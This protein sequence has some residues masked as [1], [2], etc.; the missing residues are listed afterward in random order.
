MES[1]DLLIKL[2]VSALLGGLIGMERVS[3][4]YSPA[5]LRTN[6]I[7]SMSTCLFTVLCLQ[8]IDTGKGDNVMLA[9]AIS[10]VGFLGA[11]AIFRRDQGHGRTG[12]LTTAATIWLV[13]GIGMAVGMGQYALGLFVTALSLGI[14]HFLEPFSEWL[15][16]IGEQREKTRRRKGRVFSGLLRKG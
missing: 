12:G 2:A 11:G 6:M 15:Q 3:D 14:L 7:I 13:A 1:T 8:I 5:G 16:E 9:H 10:G 4:S